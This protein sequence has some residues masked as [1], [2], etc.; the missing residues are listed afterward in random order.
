MPKL[1][2]IALVDPTR[3]LNIAGNQ[4]DVAAWNETSETLTGGMVVT[5]AKRAVKSGQTTRKSTLRVNQPL[6]KQCESTCSVVSRGTVLLVLEQTSSVE[7]TAAEREQAYDD[8]LQ[9]L[10]KADTR[11]AFINNESFYG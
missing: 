3:T 4:N 10:Q 6:Q 2:P 5:I 8:L 7:S 11:L 9:L 1:T